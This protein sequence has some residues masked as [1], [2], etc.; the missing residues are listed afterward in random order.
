MSS[1]DRPR[2]GHRESGWYKRHQAQAWGICELAAWSRPSDTPRGDTPEFCP[3]Q[4]VNSFEQI[5]TQGS[6]DVGHC[7]MCMAGKGKVKIPAWTG[8]TVYKGARC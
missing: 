5:F 8:F 6:L 3:A 1:Q 2:P 4:P 7:Y